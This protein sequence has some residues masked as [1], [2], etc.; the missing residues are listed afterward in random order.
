M[1]NAVI[2]GASSGIGK[3]LAIELATRGWNLALGARRMERLEQVAQAAREAGGSAV[4]IPLDV[5]DTA[6]IDAFWR[7]AEAALGEI[8]ALISNAGR[9]TLA[10]LVE[11]SDEDLQADVVVNLLSHLWVAKR[12]LPKMIERCRG[13]LVFIGSDVAVRPKPEMAAYTACKA[14]LEALARSLAMETHDF[15]IRTMIARLGA[16]E[17]EFGSELSLA[18]RGQAVALWQR[19]GLHL[20]LDLVAVERAA[21]TIADALA[22]PASEGGIVLFELMPTPTPARR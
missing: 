12:A 6:S 17:S 3:A 22:I 21:K 7:Q 11:C 16:T 15:G 4:A 8:D 1:R 19:W 14:G 20:S 13:D 5:T 10:P 2:T 18:R 9:S